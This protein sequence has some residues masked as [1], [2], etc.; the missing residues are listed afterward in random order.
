M[1]STGAFKANTRTK[2]GV[3]G[4]SLEGTEGGEGEKWKVGQ[5]GIG[6]DVD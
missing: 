6:S 3:E 5:E 1:E 4:R 2:L